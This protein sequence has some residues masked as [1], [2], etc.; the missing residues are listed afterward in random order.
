MSHIEELASRIDGKAAK[1]NNRQITNPIK[2]DERR[3]QKQTGNTHLKI[4]EHR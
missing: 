2:M 4:T 1:Q 3:Q